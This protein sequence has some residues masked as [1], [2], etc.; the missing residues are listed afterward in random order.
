MTTASAQTDERITARIT[1]LDYHISSISLHRA[2]VVGFKERAT[3]VIAVDVICHSRSPY[4][5]G[6]SVRNERFIY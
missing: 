1:T 2:H 3:D 6:G 4:I 5:P